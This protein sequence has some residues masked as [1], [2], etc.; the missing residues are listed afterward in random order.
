M[1]QKIKELLEA[2][3]IDQEVAEALDA[4]VSGELKKVR[5][6]AAS[7]RVKYQQ[8]Q[9]SFEE[10]KQSKDGLEEQIKTLDERIKKAKEEG[11]AELVRE[12]EAERAQKEELM[13][14]LSQLEATTRSLRIENELSRVLNQFD[15][16][17]PEVVA[18]VLKQS[19]D[20]ADDGV[21]FKN[22]E[23]VL[24]LED[25][26]KRFFENKPH[27]LKSA[28]RPGS[29]VDGVNGGAISKK[30]SEMTDDEIEAFVQK[31]GQDAFMK[32]P[33]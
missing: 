23:E 24:S 9:Q 22:G 3:K 25:G 2:G 32:L 28:G 11:K 6:E 20:V 30:K 29:G 8:L 7:W 21:K 15:V 13:Q 26:V 14:K 17:D 18:A 10:V 12:L 5:D 4:E 19:V 27:L 31:H 33:D 1:F 16:I